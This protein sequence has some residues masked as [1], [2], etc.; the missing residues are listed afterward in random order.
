M[1]IVL[2][3]PSEEWE[4]H[5]DYYEATHCSDSARVF[6]FFFAE[7]SFVMFVS[8]TGQARTTAMLKDS[9]PPPGFAVPQNLCSV[10]CITF[11]MTPKVTPIMV[12]SGM[13]LRHGKTM[14]A[15]PKACRNVS[16][17]RI[18][19]GDGFNMEEKGISHLEGSPL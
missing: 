12:R 2:P 18:F 9:H 5:P 17:V 19:W 8:R 6:Q 4:M 7:I 3:C 1:N 10:S 14:P 15:L 11:R 13:R 16:K